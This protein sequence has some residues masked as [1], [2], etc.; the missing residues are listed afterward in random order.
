MD[1]DHDKLKKRMCNELLKDV[2][3]GKKEKKGE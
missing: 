3:V 2:Q 1:D